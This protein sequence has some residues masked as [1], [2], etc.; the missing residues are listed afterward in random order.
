MSITSWDI[1]LHVA[2][3]KSTVDKNRFITMIHFISAAVLSG[4]TIL[5]FPV[6]GTALNTPGES[7]GSEVIFSAPNPNI[8]T[9]RPICM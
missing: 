4:S 8:Q 9:G 5:E 2:C 1:T 6:Q 7:V 3:P